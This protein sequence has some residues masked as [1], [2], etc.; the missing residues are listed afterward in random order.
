[1]NEEQI[2]KVLG[3]LAEGLVPADTDLWPAIR[4]R[5][6]TG[7]SHLSH[8]DLFM[9]QSL[10][11]RYRLAFAFL[12]ALLMVTALLFATPQGRAWAQ[13]F[14][15]FFTR[16]KTD[17]LPVQ[18]WQ[19]TPAQKTTTPDPSSI[20]DANQP[21]AEVE[22]RAGYDIL[23]PAW[24][25]DILSFEGASFEP[26]HRIARLFYKY[27]DT[28]GLV[29]REE[30][31]QPTDECELCGVVGASAAVEEV[32]IGQNKGEYVEGVWKLT[33]S[34]PVWESDPYLK[35][36]RWQSNGMAFE[37]LYMGPPDSLTKA[38]LI[39]IAESIK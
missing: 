26:E 30:P 39:A 12:L 5:F 28:N 23:E 32:Q 27:V 1:M 15:Q 25:P 36:L 7:K 4:K 22:Q 21:V 19:L 11:R 8:G 16:A 6:E 18:S 14:L 35:T 2:N 20:I 17:S 37:L 9:N 31:F 3:F 38:D 33:E 13:E 24:L 10:A 29:L 34:G